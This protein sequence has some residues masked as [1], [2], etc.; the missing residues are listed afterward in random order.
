MNANP[1]SIGFRDV[2][3]TESRN[4]EIGRLLGL[5]E[6]GTQNMRRELGEIDTETLVWQPYSNGQSIGALLIH[7]AACEAGWLHLVAAGHETPLD[8]EDRLMDGAAID[9][10]R[11]IWPAP[12]RK[13]LSWYYAQHDEIRARTIA[14]VRELPD[15]DEV[16]TVVWSPSR[17]CTVRWILQHIVEHEPYHMGQAVMLSLM[18]ERLSS[19]DRAGASPSATS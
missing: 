11:G 7:I 15:P 1:A 5:L 19:S 12:P 10:Y 18:R 13:P 4:E 14:L 2:S 16:R 3:P 17:T 8:L 9:Q 6:A